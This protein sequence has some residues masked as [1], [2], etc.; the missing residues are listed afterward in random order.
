MLSVP[1]KSPLV[2]LQS[3][4]QPQLCF[5]ALPVQVIDP[6]YELFVSFEDL[7]I[8]ELGTERQPTLGSEVLVLALLTMPEGQPATA[9]LLAPVV[10]N[11]A[12]NIGVQA[13]RSDFR[14]SHQHPMHPMVQRRQPC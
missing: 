9:N 8:L 13:I 2:L 11:L 14:Y 12:K 10:V 6:D 7:V 3:A 5:P 1:G 4:E